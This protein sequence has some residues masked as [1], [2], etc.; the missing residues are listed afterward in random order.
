MTVGMVT[1]YLTQLLLYIRLIMHCEYS[2]M[3][4][5]SKLAPLIIISLFLVACGSSETSTGDGDNGGTGV[6]G[7]TDTNG[8]T[9]S[10][11]GTDSNGG[12]LALKTVISD[13]ELESQIKTSLLKN[14]GTIN[15]NYSVYTL[16]AVTSDAVMATSGDANPISSTNTQESAVDEADRLKTDG[17]YLYVS[18][19]DQP[20]IKVF[21]AESSAAPLVKVHNLTTIN[22]SPLSGFYL[23]D[24]ND[25]LLAIS[26][27]GVEAYPI[28]DMW[29]APYYWQNRQTEVFDL[30][31]SNPENPTQ[32][33]KLSIDG[34]L[35][36]SRRI[37]SYLYLAT[38]HTPTPVG[39][40]KHPQLQTDVALNRSLINNSSLSDLLPSYRINDGEKLSLFESGDCFVTGYDN[41]NDQQSSIIS[42]VAINLD[43]VSPEPEAKCFMGDAET[44]YVSQNALYLA[45]TGY[46]YAVDNGVS[47]Y[48]GTPTTEIHK[49]ALEGTDATYKGSTSVAGHLGW[50][51]DLKPFRM[52]EHND[53]L[54][55]ITYTGSRQ[56][57]ESS[58]AHL[59]TLAESEGTLKVIG[60]LPNSNRPDPLG[61]PGEQIYASR[62]IGDR[63]YLVTFR[64]TD[65]L[66]VLDLSDPTD[67]YIV[68]EL[69]IDGYS[70]Y[71]HPIGENYLLGIGKDAIADTLTNNINGDG[72]GAWYQG[73]KLSLIDISNPSAPY[74]RQKLIIGGRG[75]ETAV[76]QT[77]HALTT[78]QIGNTLKMALPISLHDTQS[79]SAYYDLSD[80]RYRYDWTRDE[81]LRLNVDIVSGSIS[82]L[83]SII[84]ETNASGI[85]YYTRWESDRS[86]MIG[87]AVY[88]LHKDE[89]QTN[90]EVGIAASN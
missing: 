33:A 85:N 28:A 26:G 14:Y 6:G 88:Y 64:M 29:F 66:Y 44:L 40:K 51:Q 79:N 46:Q 34:Q 39:I 90:G 22:N 57:S 62:F 47:I 7:G 76:S 36:S 11:G 18:S 3:R 32:K 63:G 84:S 80:P 87:D 31:I 10:G 86:V 24:A 35:I 82:V 2:T 69:E 77:H 74:E 65:P 60:T 73:V 21:K 58:P 68:S 15:N 78:L 12:A 71:L 53:V 54:R 70:D 89:I 30:D 38:R 13:A 19:I 59:Y 49:F 83:P 37:G 41:P 43:T 5:L 75:T 8:G 55:I 23:R 45:T 16:E 67:P 56:E 61:K 81:L 9:G 48:S 1:L 72:R 42:V 25:Q 20:S 27:D 4:I 50:Q 17:S 52:S